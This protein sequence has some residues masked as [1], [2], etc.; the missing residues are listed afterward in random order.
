MFD[1][2]HKAED[3]A[4]QTPM[5]EQSGVPV[6]VRRL[7]QQYRYHLDAL[8]ELTEFLGA[9]AVSEFGE[10]LYA[11][12]NFV[13]PVPAG[14][15]GELGQKEAAGAPRELLEQDRPEIQ[16]MIQS[17]LQNPDSIR[18]MSNLPEVVLMAA[19]DRM[20]TSI[21][22][23]PNPSEAVQMTAVKRN[24]WA[25]KRIKRPTEKVIAY[26]L[27]KAPELRR[28]FDRISRTKQSRRS[29]LPDDR[30]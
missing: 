8:Q 23:I 19:V 26:A 16:A 25:I 7:L 15:A 29:E 10:A 11:L 18:R 17:V 12:A 6:P 4:Q 13:R 5:M 28:Y 20:G 14:A 3:Q 2:Q 21:R 9:D 22:H 30:E 24:P 1:T 27:E